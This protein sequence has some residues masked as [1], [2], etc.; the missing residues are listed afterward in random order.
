VV[1][2]ADGLGAVIEK[3]IDDTSAVTAIS[4]LAKFV[5]QE[6][7]EAFAR[8]LVRLHRS[9][10]ID[11]VTKFGVTVHEPPIQNSPPV[12]GATEI[13]ADAGETTREIIC[14]ACGAELEWKVAYHCRINK[15]RFGGKILCRSCQRHRM[16][17]LP[18]RRRRWIRPW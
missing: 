5:S 11:Y 4:S 8:R 9:K 2:K 3:R 14:E 10:P 1:I 15:E 17:R 6:T 13:S 12:I 16:Y 7:L 18:Q